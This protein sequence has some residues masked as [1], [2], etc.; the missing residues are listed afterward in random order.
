M[1]V[2]SCFTDSFV[3]FFIA[4]TWLL[5]NST[6]MKQSLNGSL[7]DSQALMLVTGENNNAYF[8]HEVFFH[9][10]FC[11]FLIFVRSKQHLLM[12]VV[13][14]CVIGGKIL[15]TR[16]DTVILLTAIL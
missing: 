11:D 2:L 1:P 7:E 12:V 13:G 9:V 16:Q 5:V 4:M 6:S 10:D 14:C 15:C 8:T 3:E